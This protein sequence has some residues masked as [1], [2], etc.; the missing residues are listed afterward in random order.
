MRRRTRRCTR[1]GERQCVR[2][3]T[4]PNNRVVF[5]IK[6]NNYRLIAQVKYGP[7]YLVYIRFIGTHAEYDRIDATSV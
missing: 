1:R 6:G 3:V 7:L 4:L 5:D 2:R